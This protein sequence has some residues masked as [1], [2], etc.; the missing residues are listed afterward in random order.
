MNWQQATRR[1]ANTQATS[2]GEAS[3]ILRQ[4]LARAGEK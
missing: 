3:V 2:Q 1:I 4:L